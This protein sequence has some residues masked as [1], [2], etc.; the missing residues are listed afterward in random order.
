[1]TGP[2][3]IVVRDPVAAAEAAAD[4]IAAILADAATARGRADFATTGGST[5]VGIYRRLAAAP[6]RDAVPWSDLHVWWGDDRFVPRGDPLS[7]VTAFDEVL[8]AEGKVPLGDERIPPFPV[9]AALDAGEGPDWC[10]ARLAAELRAAG[11]EQTDGWP[12]LDLVL[13]G[14]G[15]D[16][17]L[18]SVFPGSS[19]F[20]STEWALGIPAP[21]HME[22]HVPRVTLN[23][24]TVTV[25]RQV[26]AVV[27]GPAK[28]DIVAEILTGPRDVRRL[29]AQLAVREGA[30]WILDEAAAAKLPG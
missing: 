2:Q 6:L 5:P 13:L 8:L 10:A 30:T 15:G 1:M 16:G 25:A 29:P 12:V 21:T 27:A 9:D 11:L 20:D 18:L 4:R 7:N 24:A 17:H 22:P 23:P 14:I 3:I 26:L 19:A 28:A